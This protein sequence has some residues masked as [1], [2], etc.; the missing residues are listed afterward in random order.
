MQ[1]LAQPQTFAFPTPA[2]L[3]PLSPLNYASLP[4]NLPII[5]DNGIIT[6][7]F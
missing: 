3:P 1:H 7:T 5:I 4:G 6:S 2:I